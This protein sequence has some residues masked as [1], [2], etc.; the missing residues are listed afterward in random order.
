MSRIV[1]VRHGVTDLHGQVLYGRMPGLHLGTEGQR[2]VELLANAMA[3][4]YQVDAVFSSPMERAL[5]TAGVLAR[6]QGKQVFVETSFTEFDF[7]DWTGSTFSDLDLNPA[8]KRYNQFRSTST[9]PGG[10]SILDVQAR[11]MRGLIRLCTEFPNGTVAVVSH[12]DVI[13]SVL[14]LALGM[15]IDH[16]LRLTISPASLTEMAITEYEMHVVSMNCIFH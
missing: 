16:I 10:E 1:L 6:R 3:V 13:R 14:L 2:Q 9:A 11:A 8:W 12:A 5:D 4:R 7:G 15:S